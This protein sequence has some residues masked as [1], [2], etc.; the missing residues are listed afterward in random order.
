MALC[1]AASDPVRNVTGGLAPAAGIEPAPGLLS[2]IPV[3]LTVT[4]GT[5]D[6]ALCNLRLDCVQC[7]IAEK[8]GNFFVLCFWVYVMKVQNAWVIFRTFSATLA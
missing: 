3:K 4:V 1:R 6:N 5:K 7:C 2:L 8:Q